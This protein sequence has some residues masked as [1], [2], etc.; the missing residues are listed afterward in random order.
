MVRVHAT[1]DD[2][3]AGG[4]MV[5]ELP[6]EEAD[7]R[8]RCTPRSQRRLAAPLPGVLTGESKVQET[9]RARRITRTT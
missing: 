5:P 6:A 9:P 7:C 3:A 4:E 2:I 8:L 1:A